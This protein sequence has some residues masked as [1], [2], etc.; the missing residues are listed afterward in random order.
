MLG[1]VHGWASAG[2][3]EDRVREW[4]KPPWGGEAAR[5]RRL[6]R[7]G[8][9][10]CQA[11]VRLHPPPPSLAASSPEQPLLPSMK[12]SAARPKNDSCLPG[13]RAT[14]TGRECRRPQLG[15]ARHSASN[16]SREGCTEASPRNPNLHCGPPGG[17]ASPSGA[18]Q[19]SPEP[20]SCSQ[21]AE[22]DR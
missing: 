22:R 12:A 20:G 16:A 21:R 9:A 11:A 14:L 15:Q 18:S 2:G 3:G 1:T 19:V 10:Q 6:W 8:R 5:P 7:P 17:C 13:T 4:R